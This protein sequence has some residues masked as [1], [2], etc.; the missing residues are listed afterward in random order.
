M[1]ERGRSL[2]RREIG[3]CITVID[4]AGFFFF[5]LANVH[6]QNT[7]AA[8]SE[9]REKDKYGKRGATY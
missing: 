9:V 6:Y 5:L 1:G 4:R 3:P 8:W 7:K 2:T